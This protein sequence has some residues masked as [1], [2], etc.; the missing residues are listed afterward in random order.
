MYLVLTSE[1]KRLPL[2]IGGVGIEAPQNETV[3]PG[4]MEWNQLTFVLEGNGLLNINDTS[5]VLHGGDCFIFGKN[6]PHAYE[7]TDP[8]FHTLWIIFD[9][10]AAEQM[11]SLLTD[12]EGC[13]MFSPHKAEILLAKARAFLSAVQRSPQ[14]ERTSPLLYD[15]LMETLRQKEAEASLR[16]PTQRF[17]AAI[18]FMAAHHAEPIT[19]ED[20]AATVSLSKFTFDRLFRAAYGVT[21]FTYLTQ[22]RLQ[23]AKT[24]LSLSKDCTIKEAAL[25]CGF[26]NVSYFGAMFRRYEH[27]TPKEYQKQ[28]E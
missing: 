10:A 9:G 3:R 18:G 7:P 22:L 21:P 2:Y 24:M 19:L 23:K 5:Y 27:M 14:P 16:L 20:M 1:D 25:S 8:P 13:L 26:R 4:G 12:G 17:S 28:F 11:V 6:R 15:L